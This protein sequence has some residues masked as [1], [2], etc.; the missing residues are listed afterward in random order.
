MPIGLHNWRSRLS[1][2]ATFVNLVD[3]IRIRNVPDSYLLVLVALRTTTGQVDTTNPILWNPNGVVDGASQAL[4]RL[5][6][7]VQAPGN[8][9]I[10]AWGLNN[11]TPTGVG[12][13]NSTLQATYTAGV[14]SCV[15]VYHLYDV[16]LG[17]N[18][19]DAIRV[20]A[21]QV[22]SAGGSTGVLPALN[23]AGA[24]PTDVILSMAAR[25]GGS[26]ATN[27]IT[28]VTGAANNLHNHGSQVASTG[29]TA[30]RVAHAT[31]FEPAN[32]AP[33]QWTL[34]GSTSVQWAQLAVA[35]KM[36]A[37]ATT[38]AFR[39]GTQDSAGT[40]FPT[41]NPELSS[42]TSVPIVV[43]HYAKAG[44]YLIF[45]LYKENTAAVGFAGGSANPV[46]AIGEVTNNG[47]GISPDVIARHH[48]FY[49]LLTAADLGATIT[50]SWAGATWVSASW[51]IAR[52]VDTTTPLDV[53]GTEVDAGNNATIFTTAS[54][55]T[56][57]VPNTLLCYYFTTNDSPSSTAPTGTQ[58]GAWGEDDTTRD[59]NSVDSHNIQNWPRYSGSNTTEVMG[60]FTPRA[61]VGATGSRSTLFQP[62]IP[63]ASSWTVVKFALRPIAGGPTPITPGT[64]TINH[65]SLK[66]LIPTY[67]LPY[68]YLGGLRSAPSIPHESLGGVAGTHG[69]P[70]AWVSPTTKTAPINHESLKRLS[71]FTYKV[72]YE[73]YNVLTSTYT[74]NWEALKGFAET[75]AVPYEYLRQLTQTYPIPVLDGL[76]STPVTATYAVNWENIKPFT[77]TRTV[78]YE[79]LQGITKTA[80]IPYEWYS[81]VSIARGINYEYSRRLIE[82]RAIP[83]ES[84]GGVRNT[85][86]VNLEFYRSGISKTFGVN[87]EF[88]KRLTETRGLP[89]EWRDPPGVTGVL[90]T[91][92]DSGYLIVEID[93][94]LY[95]RVFA[96]MTYNLLS[97]HS[98]EYASAI[99][100]YSTNGGLNWVDMPETAATALGPNIK[101]FVRSAQFTLTGSKLYRIAHTGIIPSV[102]G[103]NTYK[104]FGGNMELTVIP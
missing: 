56:T 11:P 81:P 85:Y 13:G 37:S 71:L 102:P 82:T 76:G 41:Y 72:N 52:G 93:A 55:V 87:V 97:T 26:G 69:L 8:V 48:V 32:P 62:A 17:A 39:W 25:Y 74:V 94:S 68:E 58:S 103:T 36:K 98:T 73:W 96:T 5:G 35:V 61:A 12:A 18:P 14:P 59:L 50:C 63:S 20:M 22:S 104:C 49:K 27:Q 24:T 6:S 66:S 64:Y 10:E 65:E 60:F 34:A 84:L 43:P 23:L 38:P 101:K 16:E 7:V 79:Y 51:K 40:V 78:T 75:R 2:S 90:G 83:Y 45:N 92:Q 42:I 53:S 44:D 77:T 57:T 47:T 46:V 1:S 67:T 31:S 99:L 30:F 28:P 9:H 86:A 91:Y 33:C 4:T 100:Q 21:S 88:L 15:N 89:Y 80:P 3:H 54:G 95:T 29:S 19:I 70:Y